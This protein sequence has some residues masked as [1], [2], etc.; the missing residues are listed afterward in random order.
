MEIKRAKHNLMRPVRY[1]GQKYIMTEC[2][3][4]RATA[5]ADAGQLRYSAVLEDKNKN[6]TMRVPLESVEEVE[7]ER[8]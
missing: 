7:S 6:S 1:N 2:V 8:Q 3:L 5:G 4:W